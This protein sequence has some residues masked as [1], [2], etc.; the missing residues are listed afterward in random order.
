MSNMQEV[1]TEDFDKNDVKAIFE[2]FNC[3]F[4]AF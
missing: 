4:H 1:F 2:E 3:E